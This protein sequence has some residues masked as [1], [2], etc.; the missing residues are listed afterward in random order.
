MI[1]QEVKLT[2]QHQI[3]IPKQVCN[4]LHLKGGDRF[5]IVVTPGRQLILKP[6][7][8]I[9]IDDEAYQIGKKILE[10]EDQI[11]KGNFIKWSDIK[12]HHKL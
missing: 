9:D 1:S 4:E 8:L 6:K 3:T 2:T 11:K 10:A 5:E 12:R 7:K